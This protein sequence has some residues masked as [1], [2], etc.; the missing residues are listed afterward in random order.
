MSKAN[1]KGWALIT[2][3]SSGIGEAMARQFARRGHPI[4]LVARRLDRLEK[5]GQELQAKYGVETVALPADLGLADAPEKVFNEATTGGRK[6]SILVNNAGIG[7]YGPFTNYGYSDHAKTIQLNITALVELTYHFVKHMRDH[8]LTSHIANV[9]SIASYVTVPE[10]S[11]YCATK[12]FV[13]AFSE[14]LHH[15]LKNSNVCVTLVSPGGTYTEFMDN[16]GQVLKKSAHMGMMS[17]E[18][19]ASIA[20]EGMLSRK[21]SVIPGVLNYMITTLPRFLPTGMLLA[22][23]KQAMGS[24]IDYKNPNTDSS[25]KL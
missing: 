5:L 9:G 18:D 24:S 25:K 13:R 6:V 11:V 19:V 2:G 14:T 15:E 7:F 17:A 20:A 21:R 12:S 10:F 1:Q 22:G 4:I 23:A 16:A 3:A 8:G